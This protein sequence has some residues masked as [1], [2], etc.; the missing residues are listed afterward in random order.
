MSLEK[1]IKGIKKVKSSLKTAVGLGIVGLGLATGMAR[2]ARAENLDYEIIRLEMLN[3]GGITSV[4][5][6]KI[7]NQGEV[8]GTYKFIKYRESPLGNKKPFIY[9]FNG[10]GTFIE[11]K[12]LPEDFFVEAK[13]INNSGQM[14]LYKE[15]TN[16]SYT[17]DFSDSW[18]THT[19]PVVINGL[20]IIA[21]DINDKWTFVGG[22]YLCFGFRK[23]IELDPNGL[24]DAYAI[25]ENNQVVGDLKSSSYYPMIFTPRCSPFLWENGTLTQLPI[26]TN[27]PYGYNG[28]ARDINNNKQ[29]IGFLVSIE[30]FSKTHA[31][32]WENGEI[33][34]FGPPDSMAY[35]IND[36]GQIVGSAFIDGKKKAVLWQNEE[37]IDISKLIPLNSGWIYLYE[38]IDIN[39][40]GW[41]IGRGYYSK[42]PPSISSF[43][44]KPKPLEGDLN[45]DGIVNLKDLSELANHWLEER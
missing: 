26:P 18:R 29:I 24:C 41:I 16:E 31:C 44:L 17:Y 13:V 27:E 5:V 34:K 3:L 33:I 40:N 2:E 8:A 19:H 28:Y 30:R 38:A 37:L 39:N 35:A 20:S 32:M 10:S 1:I 21:R 42:Y 22:N 7:N 23:I 36:L 11:L 6:S 4:D 9:N 14:I 43:L 15:N 25:N 45:K 12:D